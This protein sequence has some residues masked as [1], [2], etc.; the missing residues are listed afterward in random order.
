M[1]QSFFVNLQFV[2]TMQLNMRLKSDYIKP[3]I[4]VW[5]SF[6]DCQLLSVSGQIE[7]PGLDESFPGG[8]E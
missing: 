8:D 6:M 2:V 3:E 5:E 1:W 4:A 7:S